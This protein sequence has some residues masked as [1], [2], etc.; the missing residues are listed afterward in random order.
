MMRE[1]LRDWKTWVAMVGTAILMIILLRVSYEIF[2][3]DAKKAD[4]IEKQHVII[5]ARLEKLEMSKAPATSKRYTSDDAARD[6]ARLES[7]IAKV[8]RQ[9]ANHIAQISAERI[10]HD[11]KCKMRWDD[12]ADLKFRVEQLETK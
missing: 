9:H 5:D 6:I 3:I 10:A 11:K 8:E 1:Q 12:V 7:L 4:E 2:S